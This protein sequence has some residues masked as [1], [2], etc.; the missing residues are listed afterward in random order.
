MKESDKKVPLPGNSEQI[1]S[2]EKFNSFLL[3]QLEKLH[4]LK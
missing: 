4:E 1:P 2:D 3:V